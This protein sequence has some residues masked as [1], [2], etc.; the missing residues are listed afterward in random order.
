MNQR[1]S[2]EIAFPLVHM[3]VG[4]RFTKKVT[5]A[6]LWSHIGSELNENPER[7]LIVHLNLL[8][9]RQVYFQFRGHE[10]NIS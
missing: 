1:M 8:I 6:D 5:K 7:F 9:L 3:L 2:K 10:V 4:K